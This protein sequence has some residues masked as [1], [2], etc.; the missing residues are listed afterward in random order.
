MCNDGKARELGNE[1]YLN[2]L[3]E[4]FACRIARSTAKDLLRAELEQLSIFF[5][6]L[7]DVAS[8]GVHTDVTFVEARQGL[9]GLYFFLFNLCQHVSQNDETASE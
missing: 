1:Q 8:K 9:V 4:F 2:R 7:N 5:R 3:Q 6:R